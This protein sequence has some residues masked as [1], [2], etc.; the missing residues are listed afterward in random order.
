M[1]TASLLFLIV[2]GLAQNAAGQNTSADK[3]LEQAHQQYQSGNYQRALDLYSQSLQLNPSQAEAYNGRAASRT[4][5]RDYAGALTDY[6]ISLELEPNDFDAR[7]GR[8]NTFYKLKRFREAKDD[9][10][11]LLSL[12]A[13]ETNTIYFQK[14]ASAKGTMQITTAQSDFKPLIYNQIGLTEYQ[15]QNYSGALAWLD[16]AIHAR[17]GEPDYYVNRGLVREKLGDERARLDF[18]K[19]LSI[20]PNHTVA[21]SILGS[22]NRRNREQRKAYLEEAIGS[23]STSV[24]AYIERAYQNMSEGKYALALQDYNTAIKLDPHDPDTWLNRGFVR[25]KL[26]DP[27]G[28]YSDFTKALTLKEDF[29]K[30][31]LNRGNLLNKTGRLDEAIQDYAVAITYDPSYAPAYYN[32]AV[33]HQKKGEQKEACRDV[34]KAE[35]LGMTVDEKLKQAVCN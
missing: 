6:S 20:N 23:D 3:L 13:G 18:E 8:A 5:L 19:A 15:L 25:E 9:Y 34:M 32:R 2:V 29:V 27:D 4:E 1:R 22:S 12:E 28:A 26:N 24:Y 21:L 10:L 35:E 31:W 17:P 16:S 33:V 14:S 30:A 11:K 7:M